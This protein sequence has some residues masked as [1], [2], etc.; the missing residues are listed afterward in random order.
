MLSLIYMQC[1]FFFLCI[2]LAYSWLFD[3]GMQFGPHGT[4]APPTELLGP[5]MFFIHTLTFF[6]SLHNI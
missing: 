4:Q 5:K 1:V 2:F 6:K 3:R